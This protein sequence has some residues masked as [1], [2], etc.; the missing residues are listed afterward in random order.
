MHIHDGSSNVPL[1]LK[2]D[3]LLSLMPEVDPSKIDF[4]AVNAALAEAFVAEGLQADGTP[5]LV[6]VIEMP[7]L[8]G[9][10]SF[11]LTVAPQLFEPGDLDPLTATILLSQLQ[12]RIDENAVKT[13]M[14]K[15]ESDTQAFE[16]DQ[17]ESLDAMREADAAEDR[18][19]AA[20]KEAQAGNI[21]SAVMAVIGA[22]L[23]G[24][25]ATIF[26]GAVLGA[27]AVA[28]AVMAL[29]EVISVGIKSNPSLTYDDGLGGRKQYGATFADFIEMGSAQRIKDGNLVIAEQND[30]GEWVD[31]NGKV[32]QDPHI[33]NPGATIMSPTQFRDMNVGLA[34]GITVFMTVIMLAGGIHALRNPADVI[35]VAERLSKFMT[36]G[37]VGLTVAKAENVATVVEVV[38]TVGNSAVQGT[39][40]GLNHRTATE[41]LNLANANALKSYI[42]SML[43]AQVQQMHLTQEFV[44]DLVEQLTDILSTV[45]R[46]IGETFKVQHQVTL[47]LVVAPG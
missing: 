45:A 28:G 47:N 31:R 22:I 16:K 20:A 37:D 11:T 39:E 33:T 8:D 14:L 35:K 32:I 3:T 42:Q 24:V 19:L 1:R 15:V 5:N 13:G 18:A 30:K 7:S 2:L 10:L 38:D 40:A 25:I 43:N 23:G 36:V 6:Q 12:I 41:Q 27:I 46:T 44:H 29:Q 4:K 17:Q 34:I 9:S 26:G 21:A